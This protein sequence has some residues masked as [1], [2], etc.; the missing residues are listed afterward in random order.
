MK[1]YQTIIIIILTL[2]STSSFAQDGSPSP[3]S[4]FGL[5][6]VVFR[7]TTENISMGGINVYTDS[8]HYNINNPASLTQLKFVNLNLGMINNFVKISDQTQ[9]QWFSAHN[10]SYF[11]LAIPVGKKMGF[12]FG[13]VPVNTSGYMLYETTDLGTN[14]FKGDGGNSRI[15]LAGAYQ[16]TKGLSLGAEFQYYFGYLER[17]N[18][19]I[20][21]ATNT[22]TKENDYESFKGSTLKFS[23]LYKYHLKNNHYLNVNANYRLS[24]TLNADYKSTTKVITPILTGQETVNFVQNSNET[25]IINFP[26]Q[27]DFG[28]GYGKR[29]HWFLGAQYTFKNL[30]KFRNIFQDPSYVNYKNA[31][32]FKFGGFWVPQYNSLTKYWKRITYRVGAYYKNTGMTIYNEDITDFGITFGLGLPAIRGISNLNLGVELGQRGKVTNF[33]VKENYI[34]L[35]IGISLND[36]WFIKHKIN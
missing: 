29:N 34:N 17:E 27:M 26:S 3:Y 1:I 7:G 32:A 19:W 12:G 30:E 2:V 5:G 4:F 11:S 9:S 16:L 22:Y 24:T 13:L 20:P 25:G 15:F 28:L 31:S 23:A 21:S 33:L 36:R 6:D 35:H 10:I 18:Y 14:S 8:I